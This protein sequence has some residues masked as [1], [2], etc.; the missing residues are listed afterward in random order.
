MI[1]ASEQAY[2]EDVDAL[3]WISEVVQKDADTQFDLNFAP[4]KPGLL[5]RRNLHRLAAAE[6]ENAYSQN[7][8]PGEI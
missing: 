6:A 8:V 3:E 7:T 4:D 1:K 2:L 5:M